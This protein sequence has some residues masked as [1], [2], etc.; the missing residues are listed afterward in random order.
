V[1]AQSIPSPFGG[2]IGF[3][4][5]GVDELGDLVIDA[6]ERELIHPRAAHTRQVGFSLGRIAAHR[7]LEQIGSDGGPILRGAHREPL[8]PTGV[9]GS[10]THSA[11]LALAAAATSEQAGGLGIDLEQ[12]RSIENLGR[13]VAFGPERDW[14]DSLPSSQRDDA[15]LTLFSAKESIYKAFFPRVGEY[16]GF[17]G[18]GVMWDANTE[19]FVGRLIADLDPRYPP[20]RTFNV[21]CRWYGPCVLTWLLLP[22]GD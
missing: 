18:A 17:E 21:G 14:L 10:I 11:G 8:W 3:A 2:A 9:V 20:S 7:A 15:A 1:I 4:A 13:F 6:A 16:F 12:R 19:Q 22:P 5:V